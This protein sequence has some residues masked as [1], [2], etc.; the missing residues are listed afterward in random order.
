M[1]DAVSSIRLNHPRAVFFQGR[2][3]LGLDAELTYGDKVIV[4]DSM[5]DF[6]EDKPPIAPIEA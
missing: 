6:N 5:F 1:Q 4:F 2:N 3:E